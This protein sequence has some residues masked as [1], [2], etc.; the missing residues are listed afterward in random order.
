MIKSPFKWNRKLSSYN[1]ICFGFNNNF[2]YNNDLVIL[3]NFYFGNF[4]FFCCRMIIL[5]SVWKENKSEM[6]RWNLIQ[7]NKS[8]NINE[9]II[10]AK[11]WYFYGNIILVLQVS[12]FSVYF[13]IFFLNFDTFSWDRLWSMWRSEFSF[14]WECGFACRFHFRW[15]NISFLKNFH[16]FWF[17]WDI[18]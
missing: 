6:N 7:K 11:L 12:F 14:F 18:E 4:I 5:L 1:S 15:E 13:V 8:Y 9:K 2:F 10:T 17:H 3:L 16:V